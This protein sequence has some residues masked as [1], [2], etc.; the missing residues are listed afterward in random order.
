MSAAFG[1]VLLVDIVAKRNFFC[2][3]VVTSPCNDFRRVKN[4]LVEPCIVSGVDR[5]W[6]AQRSDCRHKPVTVRRCC[7]LS[8]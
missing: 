3:G 4:S 7:V 5:G 2:R 1:E 6:L 8:T